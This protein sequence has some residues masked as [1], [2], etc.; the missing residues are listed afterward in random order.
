MDKI[1]ITPELLADLKKKAEKATPGPWDI[2]AATAA[3]NSF[4]S[5]LIHGNEQIAIVKTPRG[6]NRHGSTKD[7]R[8]RDATYIAAANPQVVLALVEEI[9][10]LRSRQKAQGVACCE[11]QEVEAEL[12]Q[13]IENLR[14]ERKIHRDSLKR[15]EKETDWLA[16]QLSKLGNRL[17]VKDGEVISTCPDSVPYKAIIECVSEYGGCQ[18]CWREAARKAARESRFFQENGKEEK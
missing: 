4:K 9:E 16:E 5:I 13:E 18:T 12:K 2:C 1:E 7:I 11:C 15:L 8:E 10:D 17:F 3:K 14:Q 6:L